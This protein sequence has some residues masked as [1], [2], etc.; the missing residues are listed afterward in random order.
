MTRTQPL[1]IISITK[2]AE[3]RSLRA[4]VLKLAGHEVTSPSSV[5]AAVERITAGAFEILLLGHTL[6]GEESD[7]LILVCR[8]AAPA[9]RIV[10]MIAAHS[11]VGEQEPDAQVE[12]L[13][14]PER[15][16]QTIHELCETHAMVG[17]TAPTS[18]SPRRSPQH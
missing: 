1:R 10:Q 4:A 8:N 12:S 13:A 18:S 16:L 17:I 6:N 7:Q 15:L 3:M 14:G 11:S 5:A 9:A 2:D